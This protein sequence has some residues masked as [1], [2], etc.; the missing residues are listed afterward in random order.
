LGDLKGVF[1]AGRR[2]VEAC[3]ATVDNRLLAQALITLATLCDVLG[4]DEL[5]RAYTVE[6]C[7]ID[8]Q[9][10]VRAQIVDIPT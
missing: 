1:E 10:R 9:A 8:L 3:K 5:G 4:K 7:A 2:C 6:A